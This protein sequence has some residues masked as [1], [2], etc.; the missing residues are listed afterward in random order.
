MTAAGAAQPSNPH[1]PESMLFCSIKILNANVSD[2][3]ILRKHISRPQYVSV[4]RTKKKLFC[5]A[6]R[7]SPHT[8]DSM[9][10]MARLLFFAKRPKISTFFLAGIENIKRFNI[11]S[12]GGGWRVRGDL[13]IAIL[14][15]VKVTETFCGRLMGRHFCTYFSVYYFFAKKNILK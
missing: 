11:E 9:L 2:R 15:Y 5:R 13:T 8:P 3:K 7:Q 6:V 14:F 10:G 12:G 4:T 1:P